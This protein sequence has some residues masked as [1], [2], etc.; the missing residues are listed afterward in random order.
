MTPPGRHDSST[1]CVNPHGGPYERRA[2]STRVNSVWHDDPDILAGRSELELFWREAEIGVN[3][4][5]RRFLDRRGNWGQNDFRHRKLGGPSVDALKAIQINGLRMSALWER[6]LR[7]GCKPST[8]LQDATRLS[9]VALGETCVQNP[10][11]QGVW[12][13]LPSFPLHFPTGRIRP[14]FRPLILCSARILR[15][16]RTSSEPRPIGLIHLGSMGRAEKA[17]FGGCGNTPCA[18]S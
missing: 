14:V 10:Y 12:A 15:S 18:R 2:V 3:C 8:I 16:C 17:V 7:E 13:F 9:G 1:W 5:D 6:G 11:F 4:Q